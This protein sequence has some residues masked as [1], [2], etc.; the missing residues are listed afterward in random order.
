MF[1]FYR[2]SLWYPY[3]GITPEGSNKAHP[4]LIGIEK[5]R[6]KIFGLPLDASSV[7]ARVLSVKPA[8]ALR[9]SISKWDGKEQ[10]NEI[11]IQFF[12]SEALENPKMLDNEVIR[13]WATP[14]PYTVR[15]GYL[16]TSQTNGSGAETFADTFVAR[17]HKQLTVHFEDRYMIETY[18]F[19][20]PGSHSGLILEHFK[21]YWKAIAPNFMVIN[22]SSNDRDL[23]QFSD[24]IYSLVYLIQSYGGHPLFLLEANSSEISKGKLSWLRKKHKVLATVAQ[25]FS[26][27]VWDLHGY[28]N[29]VQNQGLIWWDSVHLSSYG[30]KLTANWL[31]TELIPFIESHVK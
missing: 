13:Y 17:V 3:E 23:Q 25:E 11:R 7:R 22:L 10:I 26:I 28:L 30:Q 27:P 9:R 18:N 6:C 31:T 19:A 8:P 16:G 2:Y 14:N 15:V 21:H 12:D 24:N 1:D 4:L 20:I 5:Y 29:E